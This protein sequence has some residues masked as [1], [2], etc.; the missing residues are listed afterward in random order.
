MFIVY[1]M[2]M[3]AFSEPWFVWAC[4]T[5]CSE[6]ATARPTLYDALRAS[7]YLRALPLDVDAQVCLVVVSVHRSLMY[8]YDIYM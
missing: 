8:I 1:C 2:Y 3:S 4:I 5:I 6:A 7:V